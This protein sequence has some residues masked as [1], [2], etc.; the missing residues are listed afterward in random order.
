MFC[1]PHLFIF[2]VEYGDLLFG[3]YSIDNVRANLLGIDELEEKL[4]MMSHP[5]GR[6]KSDEI[7]KDN[8]WQVPPC[9]TMRKSL[10]GCEGDFS[11]MERVYDSMKRLLG[12][13][14]KNYSKKYYNVF[15]VIVVVFY[16]NL[17]EA[18]DS[19]NLT[20][21]PEIFY[22]LCRHNIYTDLSHKTNP[23]ISF[24]KPVLYEPKYLYN[25]Y[26][27]DIQVKL[28]R[29][30][31]PI[32]M[33]LKVL[34]K[35]FPEKEV[36]S[37]LQGDNKG[38]NIDKFDDFLKQYRYIFGV[39]VILKIL[40]DFNSSSLLKFVMN[41]QSGYNIPGERVLEL[42]KKGFDGG[43]EKFWY[44]GVP[45]TIASAF[46][47]Y[48]TRIEPKDKMPRLIN[49]FEGLAQYLATILSSMILFYD[50][51]KMES[52]FI[53]KIDNKK[54]RLKSSNFGGWL[55]L[56]S[57]ASDII[58]EWDHDIPIGPKPFS[59]KC[60][61]SGKLKRSFEIGNEIRN[62]EVAHGPVLTDPFCKEQIDILSPQIENV[63]KCLIEGFRDIDVVM[64]ITGSFDGTTRR[65][66][67]RLLKGTK[68]RCE[69]KFLISKNELVTG[70]LYLHFD[71]DILIPILPF[72]RAKVMEGNQICSYFYNRLKQNEI[73]NEIDNEIVEW[74]S[75][76]CE[77]KNE[78]KECK[79]ESLESQ[80]IMEL[81]NKIESLS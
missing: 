79:G 70:R 5:D 76:H 29:D 16:K 31:S 57:N 32:N 24:F 28:L 42:T 58:K 27:V 73:D 33:G 62:E 69:E 37:V 3:E 22:F 23:P 35:F 60:L 72:V 19:D 50:S 55:L 18:F 30:V 65:Y 47:Q 14:Q 17:E 38:P 68:E 81:I 64:P 54:I 78:I 63:K 26:I 1:Y 51:S 61:T 52:L 41:E 20:I 13:Y 45:F 8:I 25:K 9:S 10:V 34:E 43:S 2:L 74:K 15:I 36:D 44:E 80:E 67:V 40:A 77:R 39:D 49:F 4:S 66:I 59:L 21:T 71:V 46:W 6:L 11:L 48:K 75:F 12:L 53:S 56:F 7:F